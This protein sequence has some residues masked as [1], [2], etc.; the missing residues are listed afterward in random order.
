MAKKK[1]S[2]TPA[3]VA[4]DK[5]KI[6]YAPHA[7]EHHTDTTRFGEEAAEALGVDPRRIFKTLMA[8]LD[9]PGGRGSPGDGEL[10]VAIVPVANRLDLKAL[11]GAA[12]A[13]RAALADAHVAERA[14][15]MVV[16]GISPVGQRTRHRTFL[17]ASAE[18]YDTIH[19]SAGKRGLQ[20][21][22]SPADLLAVTGGTYAEVAR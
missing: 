15:G 22:L 20:I 14:T 17:D 16:G 5:A 10:V 4:L 1:H 2:G 6:A 21:E 7:Y 3:T 12:G 19:V 11:A 18:A 9:T 8:E 13:K